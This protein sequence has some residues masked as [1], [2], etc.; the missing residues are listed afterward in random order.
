[1]DLTLGRIESKAQMTSSEVLL[2]DWLVSAW[3]QTAS[4]HKEGKMVLS[5]PNLHHFSVAAPAEKKLFL[6]TP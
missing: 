3:F 2:L 6:L 1:M 4:L 5:V